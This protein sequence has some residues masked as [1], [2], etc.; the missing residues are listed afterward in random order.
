M[1][2]R[3]VLIIMD[4]AK[5]SDSNATIGHGFLFQYMIFYTFAAGLIN[6]V[7]HTRR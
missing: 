7:L 5:S 4:E 3:A 1:L 2:C 6:I